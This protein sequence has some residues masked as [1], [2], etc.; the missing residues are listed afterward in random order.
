MDLREYIQTNKKLK[1][2]PWELTRMKI[3]D[4]FI[5]KAVDKKRIIADVGSGD[6][7]LAGGMAAAHPGAKVFAVDINYNESLL[8]QLRVNKPSNLFFAKN[9]TSIKEPAPV[10]AFVLMDVLEHVEHPEELLKELLAPKFT[11]RDT[12]FIITVPA[13][14]EL[15]SQHDINLGHFRRYNLKSLKALLEP[16]SLKIVHSGY[17]FN[18]LLAI[19]RLQ[20]NREKKKGPGK[21]TTE[22]IHNWNGGRFLT[23]II[24]SLL[25]I[26]FKI[27]WYLARIGIKIPGLTCYCICKSSPS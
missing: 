27:S 2:H 24:T 12:V 14:Q 26:E 19:R 7:F 15:F 8:D 23:Q 25:W 3:L 5:N 9:V 17:C 16:L 4:C 18:S 20:I 1:R 22:G 10:N 11:D 6:A 21:T 13:Y